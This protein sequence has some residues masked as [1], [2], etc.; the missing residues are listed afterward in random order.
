MN[1]LYKEINDEY[2]VVIFVGNRLD[3]IRSYDGMAQYI[4]NNEPGLSFP[5][6]SSAECFGS[7]GKL[8]GNLI[9]PS[10]NSFL[11]QPLQ[12]MI[13]VILHLSMLHYYMSYFIF[14][15]VLIFFRIIKFM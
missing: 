10:L 8:R 15:V 6:Y 2:E 1:A 11:I 13:G 9:F 5:I 3:S 4:S 12:H 14:G 7:S